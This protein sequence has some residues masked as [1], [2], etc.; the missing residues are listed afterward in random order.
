MAD[1]VKEEEGFRVESDNGTF[2]AKHVILATG[3]MADLAEKI[4]LR[5]KPG[6]EPRIKTIIETDANGQTS[7]QA[8]GPRERWPA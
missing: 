2:Q 7:E 1:V 5:T 8:F 3:M 4:G 6:T